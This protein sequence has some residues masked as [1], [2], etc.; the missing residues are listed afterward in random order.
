MPHT[1][2]AP[3]PFSAARVNTLAR[4]S[5]ALLADPLLRQDPASVSVAYWLRRAQVTRL[6]EEH[7]RRAVTEPR[8]Q[9]Q[10]NQ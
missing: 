10:L 6:A 7:A 1:T 9:H 5:A 2:R 3:E 8:P 4:L